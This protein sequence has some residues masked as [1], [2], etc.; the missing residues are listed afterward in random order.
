MGCGSSADQDTQPNVVDN[1]AQASAQKQA[2]GAKT[3]QNSAVQDL[4]QHQKKLGVGG[5]CSVDQVILISDPSQQF[6][7]KKLQKN[8]SNNLSLWQKE[9]EIMSKLDHKNIVHLHAHHEDPDNFYVVTELCR[10]GELFDRIVAMKKFNEK[11]AAGLVRVMLESIRY[12]HQQNIVHRDLKPENY[13][14]LSPAEDSELKL[15][16]FGCAKIVSDNTVYKDLVGT[17]FYLAPESADHRQR[18]TGAILK[19]S[20][21][22]SIGVIT[23]VMVTGKPPF[24]GGSNQAIFQAILRGNVKYTDSMSSG[25]RDFLKKT[26]VHNPLDRLS[27]ADALLHPWV[28]GQ[29][30]D[31]SAI[32]VE[33]ID[34]LRSFAKQCKLKKALAKLV[35]DEMT[36]DEM[37][38]LRKA[39]ADIDADGDGQIDK[40]EIIRMLQKTGVN[41]ADAEQ[42]AERIMQSTDDDGNGAISIEEFAQAEVAAQLADPN[43]VKDGF[44]NLDE[45]GDGFV[46]VHELRKAFGE[47]ETFNA[48]KDMI[49][50]IDADGD[51]RI[52]WDEFMHAMKGAQA[53]PQHAGQSLKSLAE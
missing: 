12:C 32:G 30:A 1:Q 16:D 23:Y 37:D 46:D 15:I 14:F 39:F 17:P 38:V 31:E 6:A 40:G 21:V 11:M 8:D 22:W 53:T 50:E 42:E 7:L 36:E 29:D 34:S 9:I 52:S 18:R 35:A 49:K 51:G 33:V 47:G 5:S 20:D 48:V 41:D 43:L 19:A 13:V 25:C 2:A 3:T 24:Y 28:T 10:G 26:L 27:V 45:D 4:Y 44:Q